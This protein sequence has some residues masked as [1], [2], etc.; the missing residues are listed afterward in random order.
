MGDKKPVSGA[1]GGLPKPED[2]PSQSSSMG[3]Q[4]E[5]LQLVQ[6]LT[7]ALKK[8]DDVKRN[9]RPPRVYSVG[10]NFKTWHSQFVQYARLVKIG[11]VDRRAYLL[12]QLDQ[13]AF[14]AV[15][16]LKLSPALSYQEFVDKVIERFDS[17]K[18]KED[19]KL[20][21]R[22]RRQKVGEDVDTFADALVDLAENAYPEADYVFKDEL[23]RDQFIQGISVPD[24]MREKIFMSQPSSIVEAVRLVRRLESARKACMQTNPPKEKSVSSKDRV[25]VITD[26]KISKELR[27][28]KDL[29]SEMNKRIQS[30]EEKNETKSTS[31]PRRRDDVVCFSCGNPGHFARDC[32][33]KST[34]NDNRG[35]RPANQAPWKDWA[36]V[37]KA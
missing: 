31:G 9:V 11:E 37:K 13:P 27:E 10:Q 4:S 23:A 6:I 30:L 1:E 19:Y 18:T 26:D 33:M 29:V 15:E 21:L 5:V 12:T 35:L 25:S 24:E 32:K 22:A 36:N 34:G 17:G 14:K 3:A 28:L 8:E 20:Q 7:G 2:G 16:L